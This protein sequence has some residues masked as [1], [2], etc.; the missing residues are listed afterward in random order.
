MVAISKHMPSSKPISK[1]AEVATSNHNG[2]ANASSAKSKAD[3]RAVSPKANPKFAKVAASNHN[4]KGS[5]GSTKSKIDPR[6]AAA[7][8]RWRATSLRVD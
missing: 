7:C 4:G 6:V 2:K 8:A 1:F 5:A 3:P